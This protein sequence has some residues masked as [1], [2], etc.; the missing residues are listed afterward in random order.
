M[1][2]QFLVP[3]L[4]SLLCALIIGICVSVFLTRGLGLYAARATGKSMLPTIP[5]DALI[6]LARRQPSVGDIVH[7]KNQRYNYVHRLIG[8]DGEDVST[9]GDNCDEP[10]YA[11][12]DDIMG[13][14][15]LYAPFK[16]FLVFVMGIVGSEATL[17]GTWSF[18]MLRDAWRKR[19]SSIGL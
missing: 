19:H 8:I 12:I 1:R 10:E 17:A 3:L 7:V 15:V 14:V 16:V 2:R 13:V 4:N 6:I 18:S 9:K 5:S 11:A